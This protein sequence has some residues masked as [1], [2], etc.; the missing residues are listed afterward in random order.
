MQDELFV[1]GLIHDIG[2]LVERQAF[3]DQFSEV[4]DLVKENL[5]SGSVSP[6]L[7]D[8]RIGFVFI[9]EVSFADRPVR[10]IGDDRSVHGCD[11]KFVFDRLA[12]LHSHLNGGSKKESDDPCKTCSHQN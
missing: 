7:I 4:I 6:D 11:L 2:T 10:E 1:A 12:S 8:A 5:V 9:F 3:P